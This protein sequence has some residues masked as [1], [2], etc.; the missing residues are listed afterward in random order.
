MDRED[1]LPTP[2]TG[3]PLP[4]EVAERYRLD[5]SLGN[6]GMGEVFEATDLTLHRRVAVKLMSSSLVQDEPARARFLREARALAQVNS[7]NVV[8]VYDAGEDAERPYLVME[9]VEGTTLERELRR[10]GRIEPVR[11]VAIAMGIAAGLAAA[12]ERGIVHRDVKPSNVF[13]TPS[14]DAKIGDFGIARLERPDATL[15]LAGQ[16]FGS[17]PY[18]SPE[19]AMGGKVDARSD[20]YSLG[21]V[22]FQIIAGTPPFSGDD[23]VSLAYQ[24]VHTT[25]PRVDA[26][27]P[28]VPAELGALVAGLM[29]KDPDNRP[30]SAEEVRRALASMPIAHE[31]PVTTAVVPVTATAVLPRRAKEL[32][33]RRRPW[34]PAAAWMAG[35]LALLAIGT[36]ALLAGGDRTAGASPTGPVSTASSSPSSS[37]STVVPRTPFAAA[38]A[39]LALTQQLQDAGAID[40]KL[41]SDIQQ[42]VDEAVNGNGHGNGNGDGHGHEG[43][44]TDALKE[45]KNNVS[46]AVDHGTLSTADGQRLMDAIDRLVQTLTSEGD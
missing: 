29:A 23:A 24:H 13:L 21:C 12:H 1:V 20:L 45:L 25:P 38:A 33:R 42:V 34:W 7:P 30:A 27:D 10:T 2:P 3:S 35:A 11:A 26:L 28:A 8:A 37:P 46:D 19:Q 39:L 22:L 9:L 5:R 6:G 4:T 41:A 43:D 36:A 31:G 18:M 40:P 32:E 16:A 14:D 44:A 17:P 15:T